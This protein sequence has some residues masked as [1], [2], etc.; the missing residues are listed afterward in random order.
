[1]SVVVTVKLVTISL[2]GDNLGLNSITGFVECFV[3][4][5][6]CRL[7]GHK[8]RIDALNRTTSRALH[9]NVQQGLNTENALHD[10]LS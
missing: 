4:H 2:L 8:T 5:H 9:E 6:Y 1:M 3:A 7:Q 10:S